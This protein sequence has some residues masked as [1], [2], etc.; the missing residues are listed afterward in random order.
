MTVL[1]PMLAMD[2]S[3]VDDNRYDL[4]QLLYNLAWT[5]QFDEIDKALEEI[6]A[7]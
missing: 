3:I 2:A 6:S 7:S 5:T 4:R 1:T